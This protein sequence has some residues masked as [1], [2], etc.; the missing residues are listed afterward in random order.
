MRPIWLGWAAA[1][2]SLAL[3]VAA[4]AADL[5]G[6]RPYGIAGRIDQVPRAVGPHCFN[7]GVVPQR[8]FWHLGQP[9]S[10]RWRPDGR[11][12]DF[13]AATL[14]FLIQGGVLICGEMPDWPLASGPEEMR[15]GTVLQ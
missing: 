3:I 4:N 15:G 10:D 11:Q 5:A 8:D 2:F 1:S 6:P 12:N 9:A 13:D 14:Q 7:H